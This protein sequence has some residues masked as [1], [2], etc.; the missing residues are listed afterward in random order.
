V[1]SDIR[2]NWGSSDDP[3]VTEDELDNVV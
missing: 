1:P 2:G 3:P